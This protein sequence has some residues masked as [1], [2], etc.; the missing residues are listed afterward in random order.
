M[1]GNP[2]NPTTK[3]KRICNVTEAQEVKHTCYSWGSLLRFSEPAGR[4]NKTTFRFNG[5]TCFR[6]S[7]SLVF[8]QP[9]TS[10]WLRPYKQRHNAAVRDAWAKQVEQ[11]HQ[12]S[13]SI[14]WLWIWIDCLLAILARIKVFRVQKR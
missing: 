1:P 6:H 7:S 5:N 13:L 3:K 4:T 14:A 11:F 8:S 12:T 9:T 10:Q 2:K